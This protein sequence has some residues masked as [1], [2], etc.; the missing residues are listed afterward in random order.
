VTLLLLT[1]LALI[2]CTAVL[3]V[4][5]VSLGRARQRATIAQIGAYGFRSSSAPAAQTSRDLRGV[6]R[7]AA[8]GIGGIVLSQF[9]EERERRL[10]RQLDTAGLYQ[11]SVATFLGYRVIAA[12]ALAIG[13]PLLSSAAGSQGVRAVFVTA[14]LT[15][16]GWSLP[17]YLVKRRARLRLEQ[18]DR[19]VPELVDLLVTTI[20]AGVGFGG[21]LQLAAR[22]IR[23]PLGDEL[24][25]ALQQ[26]SLG[27][28]AHQSLQNLTTRV[29]SGALRAFSQALIQG[30]TLGV[31]IGKVMRDLAIEM[32]T[33]RRQAAE[34]RAQKAP[35]KILFPLV[36]L[37]LPALFIV[38]LGPVIA[39]VVQFFGEGI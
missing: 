29:E 28:T 39:R 10:R 7:A 5:S 23:G 6:V 38:S 30:E 3:V 2:G 31:S 13:I 18:V 8:S 22:S 21:G 25:L 34:E 36:G 4:H 15:L 37:I 11:T 26:Q 9:N 16:A 27:L 20:E 35:T 14:W 1:G 24:R 19:E 17:N 32:R 33:R 12:S